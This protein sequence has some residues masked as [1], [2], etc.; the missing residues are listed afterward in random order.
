M[1]SDKLIA[2]GRFT[3]PHGIRGEL[4]F[5][6]YVSEMELL[7]DLRDR[8]VRLHHRNAPGR[9]CKIL[10]WRTIHSRILMQIQGLR[11][12]AE[13]ELLRDY[14]IHIPRDWFPALPSG[15]YYW[16]EIEGLAVYAGDGLAM[17]VVTDIIHTGS[18]DVYVVTR[19]D[20]ETL[21]PALKD[22]VRT[23]DLEHGAMHLFNVPG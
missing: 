19:D 11:D 17:G 8:K 20:Q 7:P 15:E 1:Q 18:N 22:V 6:P 14:E 2:V 5:L 16:F 12:P 21:V 13:A 10:A 4:V 23:I 3:R 9:T